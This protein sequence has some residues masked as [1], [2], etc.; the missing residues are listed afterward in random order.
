M[1]SFNS[2][3]GSA[4]GNK[5]NETLFLYTNE[6]EKNVKD[7]YNI[8]SCCLFTEILVFYFHYYLVYFLEVSL[9][10]EVAAVNM[11]PHFWKDL[12]LVYIIC[13]GAYKALNGTFLMC[14]YESNLIASPDHS[15]QRNIDVN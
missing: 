3:V 10:N 15:H 7:F 8:F 5:L 4:W 2:Y 1:F 13:F 14:D 6:K 9:W 11:A 12:L